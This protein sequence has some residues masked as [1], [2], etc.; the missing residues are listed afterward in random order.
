[1]N[2]LDG[3]AL[4]GAFAETLGFDITAATGRCAGCRRVFELANTRSFVTAMG[5]VMRCRHCDSVLA[6]IVSNRQETLVNL[7]GLSY[8]TMPRP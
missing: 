8:L 1:M 7:S 5:K 6:V 2:H 3:N 4:A